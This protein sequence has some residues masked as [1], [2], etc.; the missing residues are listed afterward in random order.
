MNRAW[1][2]VRFLDKQLRLAAAAAAAAA[3]VAIP[4]ALI[5]GPMI[6]RAATTTSLIAGL[7]IMVFGFVIAFSLLVASVAFWPDKSKNLKTP[8]LIVLTIIYVSGTCGLSLAAAG[9]IGI[10][11]AKSDGFHITPRAN[12]ELVRHRSSL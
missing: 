8:A 9:F 3:L 2:K 4:I 6:D 10:G 11:Y 12:T 1:F 5:G 7:S